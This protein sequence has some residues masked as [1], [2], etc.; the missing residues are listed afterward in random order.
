MKLMLIGIYLLV[1]AGIQSL[2]SDK[3]SGKTVSL[4]LL[5]VVFMVVGLFL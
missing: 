1:I 5:S 3:I 4:T 2:D